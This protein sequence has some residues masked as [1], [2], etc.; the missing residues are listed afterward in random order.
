MPECRY[1]CGVRLYAAL[2]VLVFACYGSRP[3]HASPPPVVRVTTFYSTSGDAYAHWKA[4]NHAAPPYQTTF[5]AGTTEVAFYVEYTTPG[6]H[7]HVTVRLY[8]R[9]AAVRIA[10]AWQ[11][12]TSGPVAMVRLSPAGGAFA[13]GSYT[14]GL[15]VG[16]HLLGSAT[17][18]ID[19]HVA[20]VT[21]SAFRVSTRAAVDV[22]AGQRGFYPLPARV[23]GFPAGTKVIGSVYLFKGAVAHVTAEQIAFDGPRGFRVTSG[24]PLV[25]RRASDGI[26]HYL[27]APR[28]HAFPKGRYVAVV[29]INGLQAAQTTFTVG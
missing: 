20:G 16:S 29:L 22:W 15:V 24:Q 8:R 5:A 13:K 28:G 11:R 17:F 9:G 19:G 23:T 7:S 1:K 10:R 26:Y 12:A 14:A 2:T 3:A 4:S 25:Y 21:I 27:Y 18:L 6:R